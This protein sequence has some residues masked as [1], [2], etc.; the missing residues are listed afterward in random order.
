MQFGSDPLLVAEVVR[1]RPKS[2]QDPSGSSSPSCYGHWA[3]RRPPR[4]LER[5]ALTVAQH[6]PAM[7]IDSTGKSRWGTTG[8]L[9]GPAINP[10]FEVVWETLKPSRHNPGAGGIETVESA[11]YLAIAL[12]VQVGRPLC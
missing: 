11:D 2:R 1:A 3:Y 12:R 8:G 10:Y 9:S 4:K 7:A 6:L 5:I